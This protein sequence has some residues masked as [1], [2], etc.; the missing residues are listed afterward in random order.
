[1]SVKSAK[2]LSLQEQAALAIIDM[3]YRKNFSIDNAIRNDSSLV[4]EW[5]VGWQT[6]NDPEK[7]ANFFARINS[8]RGKALRGTLYPQ[9][10]STASTASSPISYQIK[11]GDTMWDIS[12]KYNVPVESIL[13][14]NPEIKDA[15]SIKAGQN[16]II[17]KVNAQGGW[18]SKYEMGGNI[19]DN[20]YS[21]GGWLNKYK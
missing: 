10:I 11:S 9:I 21:Q 4:D 18:L 2:D 1:M 5:A 12:Q 19:Q 6:T 20:T 3:H 7:R 16:L 17:P 15:A 8:D 13:K 14:V